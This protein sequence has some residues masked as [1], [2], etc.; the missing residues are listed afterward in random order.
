MTLV[1]RRRP[2]KDCSRLMVG[3]SQQWYCGECSRR[4]KQE[5]DARSKVRQR[6][7]LL[8]LSESEIE[9]RFQSALREIRKQP[10]QDYVA[11]FN[12]A[13]RYREP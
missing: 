7:P 1:L 10:R 12:F 3:Y 11:T 6:E 8:D 5:A 4:R 13:D 2:C 9:A